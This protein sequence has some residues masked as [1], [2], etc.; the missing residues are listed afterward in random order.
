MWRVPGR[1]RND[2]AQVI[3]GYSRPHGCYIGLLVRDEEERQAIEKSCMFSVRLARPG[4]HT[5]VHPRG[6]VDRSLGLQVLQKYSAQPKKK[7]KKKAA[8]S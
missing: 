1:A 8:C 4:H 3:L 6:L 2:N 7:K 5:S